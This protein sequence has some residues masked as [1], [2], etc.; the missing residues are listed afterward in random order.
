VIQAPA[1]KEKFQKLSAFRKRPT[2]LPGILSIESEEKR[3]TTLQ[4]SNSLQ[5]SSTQGKRPTSL[6]K[7]NREIKEESNYSSREISTS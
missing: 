5:D 7:Q 3:T 4:K 1:L 2:S 6:P